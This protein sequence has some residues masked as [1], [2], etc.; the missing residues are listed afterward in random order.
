MPRVGFDGRDLLRPRTGVVNNALHLARELSIAHPSDVLVYVDAPPSGETA[1]RQREPAPEGV[2]LRALAAPPV[3]W[4]HLALPLALRR[5]RR[6]VFHSP[7]GTLPVWA[8]CRQVVTIHDT[9]AA[10]EPRWFSP[11]IGWQLRLTQ[12]R[13]AHAADRVIAVSERTRTDLAERFGVPIHKVTVVYNGVDHARFRPAEVDAEAIARRY[14]VPHPFVLC[15]GSLMP[16]RNA[17]RLLR[18]VSKLG[19]G[20]LFVGRDIWGTDPTQR[21]AANNGWD[22]A[23]FAGYVPDAD[24]PQ[25]YAAAR[26]FAY[27]SLYEGFGIP[28]VEAMA[29]GTPV[30]GSNAGALPEVLGDAA[31]LVDARD[32]AAL[33]EAI[34][35][36][37]EDQGAL[38]RRG[39][40]RA[41]RY[42][43]DVAAEQTWQVYTAAVRGG[44]ARLP[45]RRRVDRAGRELRDG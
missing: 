43:W 17:P 37:A 24:L 13:A 21:I 45:R 30:V 26:V 39:L 31:L 22:W 8:A 41:A 15:V 7:T 44:Q 2:A 25:L 33:A 34:R 6:E 10:I 9:F 16:W 42:R 20:L 23:K 40:A 28:P 18:A 36:A 38:R 32:E 12:R 29:C 3:V 35:A 11:R 14:G 4:K 19:L 1:S 5:D 27:P